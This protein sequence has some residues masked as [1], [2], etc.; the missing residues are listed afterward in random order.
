M[1]KP[2]AANMTQRFDGRSIDTLT[3]FENIR[4]LHR[5]HRRIHTHADPQALGAELGNLRGDPRDVDHCDPSPSPHRRVRTRKECP[6][7]CGR[8]F[9]EHSGDPAVQG[10]RGGA[11]IRDGRV[12]GED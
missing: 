7:A 9:G 6:M 5:V 2:P 1:I 10:R 4:R 3:C 11:D 8:E 12:G